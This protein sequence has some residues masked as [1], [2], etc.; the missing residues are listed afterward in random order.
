MTTPDVPTLISGD[1]MPNL[2]VDVIPELEA[3]TFLVDEDL[4][5]GDSLLAWGDLDGWVNVVCDVTSVNISRGSSRLQGALTRAEAGQCTVTLSD[6]SR[7]FDPLVNADA[8]HQDTPVRVRA[9]AYDTAGERWDA[10]LFTGTIHDLPVI[11]PRDEPPQVTL[12]ASDLV[13][14]LS[15]WASAGRASHV[16]AGDN[17][18]QRA[19][20]LINETGADPGAVIHPD[21]DVTGYAATLPDAPLARPW[22]ELT[23][24]ADAELG[25]VWVTADNRLVVRG[26]SSELSGPVRGTFS[27]V[28]GD[29]DP[30]TP[31]CCVLDGGLV[32]T[33]GTEQMTN[34]AIAARRIPDTAPT[35][36]PTPAVITWSSFPSGARWGWR[37]T[38]RRSLEVSS[39]AETQAWVEYLVGRYSSPELR[40]DSIRPAPSPLDVDSALEAWPAVCRTDIGDRWA[41]RYRPSLG[42][43]LDRTVGVLGIEHTI[44][45]DGWDVTFHTVDAPNV[46]P[47]NPEG[48]V[49]VDVSLLDTGDVLAP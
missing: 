46:S 25:R 7:R 15:A 18:L 12:S 30:D 35:P 5:D 20:R 41:V 37:V 11:Y 28:H 38:E 23:A 26:R 4:V 39:D 32:A 48:F 3:G 13:A 17:L 22:E 34:R 33:L 43:Q 1:A 29:A 45:P 21:V 47:G 14:D 9:W 8:I 24:A 40:V 42:P 44:T 16:G 19:Q 31:H 2:A 36:K 49:L 27:D 10:T 6:T